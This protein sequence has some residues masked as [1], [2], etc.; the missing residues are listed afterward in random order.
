MNKF[1]QFK[2]IVE[3]G[4]GRIMGENSHL[5]IFSP[6][7]AKMASRENLFVEKLRSKME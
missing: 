5:L 6:F 1:L 2:E 4:C 3:G 7:A